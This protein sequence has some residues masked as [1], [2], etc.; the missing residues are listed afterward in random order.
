M[1]K[2]FI[3]RIIPMVNSVAKVF[4]NFEDVISSK[5][6]PKMNRIADLTFR[7][8]EKGLTY[9]AAF[10]LAVVALLT[11]LF[12]N[13]SAVATIAAIFVLYGFVIFFLFLPALFVLAL[14]RTSF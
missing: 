3:K 11:V 9:I 2:I 10:L 12:T 13:Y 14:F 6:F 5:N 7:Y 4:F 8:E 1:K